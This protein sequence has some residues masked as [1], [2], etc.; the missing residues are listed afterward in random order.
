[1]SKERILK[2]TLYSLLIS[3]I[4]AIS[5]ALI[6]KSFNVAT[7]VSVASTFAIAILTVT[8]V[9]T[10]TNQLVV[11][12]QQMNES[13]KSREL[14]Y[15]PLPIIGIKKFKLQKP[16]FFYAP[17]DDIHC[18][19]SRYFADFEVKNAGN[20]PAICVSLLG[21]L[22]CYDFAAKEMYEF[23]SKMQDK[24]PRNFSVLGE[25]DKRQQQDHL[26]FINDPAGDFILGL[27]NSKKSPILVVET[28][29]KNILGA[30]FLA[31]QHFTIDTKDKEQD[32]IL[33]NWHAN[34]SSFENR[35]ADEL[36]MLRKIAKTDQKEWCRGPW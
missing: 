33:A 5:Y 22:C 34:M 18:V 26:M 27:R 6:D 15:Q 4:L 9:S 19:L 10:T 13:I 32:E 25:R 3:V 21:T 36:N 29:Y 7:F 14:A 31:K 16:R 28:F 12:Q 20:S 8:Y 1:M 11:M 23:S 35:F 30:C 24:A 17:P 2:F